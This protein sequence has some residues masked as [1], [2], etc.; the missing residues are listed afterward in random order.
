VSGWNPPRWW[1]INI[2]IIYIYY[3]YIQYVYDASI[4]TYVLS[5]A[6]VCIFKWFIFR[7]FKWPGGPRKTFPEVA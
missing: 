1:N 7:M 3:I 6:L 4:T 5:T 2:Y